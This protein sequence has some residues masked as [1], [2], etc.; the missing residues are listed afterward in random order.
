M[1][2]DGRKLM[3]TAFFILYSIFVALR[4]K[5]RAFFYLEIEIN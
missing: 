5:V 4:N 2:C 1:C 3:K